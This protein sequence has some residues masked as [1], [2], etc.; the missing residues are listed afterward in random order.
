MTIEEQIKLARLVRSD[1]GTARL[2]ERES[3]KY[4]DH[5]GA[6]VHQTY[7]VIL[8]T[9]YEALTIYLTDFEK[10]ELSKSSHE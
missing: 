2:K 9:Y 6:A 1:I 7:Q 4:G 5:V 8:E 3:R 10:A